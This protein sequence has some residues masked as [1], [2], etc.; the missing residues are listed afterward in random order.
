MDAVWKYLEDIGGAKPDAELAAWIERF[1]ADKWAAGRAYWDEIRGRYHGGVCC[2]AK[3]DPR[4]EGARP[5]RGGRC[6][7]EEVSSGADVFDVCLPTV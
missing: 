6:D 5:G 4:S 7:G 1:R 3:Y 2:W